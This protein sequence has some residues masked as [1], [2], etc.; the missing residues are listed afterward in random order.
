[1]PH[2]VGQIPQIS[3]NRTLQTIENESFLMGKPFISAKSTPKNAAFCRAS[4]RR[5][6]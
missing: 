5:I 6:F 4:I 1:M 3:P 2:Q